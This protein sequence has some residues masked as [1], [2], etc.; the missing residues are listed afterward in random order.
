MRN[1][2]FNACNSIECISFFRG[3]GTGHL[4]YGV[5]SGSS[6]RASTAAKQW[7]GVSSKASL[8][9]SSATNQ[10]GSTAN[11]VT[12][13]NSTAPPTSG[14]LGKMYPY[15]T[16]TGTS[17][18]LA[19]TSDRWVKAIVYQYK[20]SLL[21]TTTKRTKTATHEFRHALS[22]AHPTSSSTV[23]VMQQGV[24]NYYDLKTYDKDSLK[25]KGGK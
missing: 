13:F 9:Y 18:S 22:V 1:Y 24:L 25:A 5:G 3:F 2:F 20:N 6:S 10:Y 23:A 7:N 11:V 19:T 15:K 4:T 8:P 17:A 16:Y 14:A 21:D 12:H